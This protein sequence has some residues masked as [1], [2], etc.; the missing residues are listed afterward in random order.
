MSSTEVGS[1]ACKS[2]IFC[3]LVFDHF[4]NEYELKYSNSGNAMYEKI[5]FYLLNFLWMVKTLLSKKSFIKHQ[6]LPHRNVMILI[7]FYKY[8]FLTRL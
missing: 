8:V 1:F 3:L 6:T 5:K 7:K 2:Q 4:A